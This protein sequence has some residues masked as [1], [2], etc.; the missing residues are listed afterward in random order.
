MKAELDALYY[1]L[2]GGQTKRWHTWP[3]RHAETVAEHTF[4]VVWICNYLAGMRITFPLLL[5]ALAHD[6]AEQDVGDLPANAKRESPILREEM[7]RLEEE[8]L[9]TH[10]LDFQLSTFE[11]V[12]LNAADT[13]DAM[14]FCIRERRLGNQNMNTAWLR[15]IIYMDT[16]HIPNFRDN[17]VLARASYLLADL[18]SQWRIANHESE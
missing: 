9:K 12:V 18:R 6:V 5:A 17:D 4:G 3:V 14:F 16:E 7:H 2:A 8:A 10:Y 13:L 11:T 15:L 1:A